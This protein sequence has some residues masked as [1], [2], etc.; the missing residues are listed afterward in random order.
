MITNGIISL[1]VESK[2]VFPGE[3]PSGKATDFESVYRGFESL[4]PSLDNK[5]ERNVLTSTPRVATGV[6]WAFAPDWLT[7]EEA[8]FLSGYDRGFM[9]QVVE[10]DGV[11]LDNAGRIEKRSL[12]EWLEVSVELVAHWDD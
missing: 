8:C 3:W 4:L 12:W 10:V 2:H 11:D 5:R 7:F 6:D 1:R 9:L